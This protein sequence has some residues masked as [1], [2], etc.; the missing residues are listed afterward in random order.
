M[1]SI[2][3]A[4][5]KT[6]TCST[7]LKWK[8]ENTV[9]VINSIKSKETRPA[10]LEIR[11]EAENW[12]LSLKYG[13]ANDSRLT[14]NCGWGLSRKFKRFGFDAAIG[15]KLSATT[16]RDQGT[17]PRATIE[18]YIEPSPSSVVAQIQIINWIPYDDANS[19]KCSDRMGATFSLPTDF[20]FGAVVVTSWWCRSDVIGKDATA[21]RTNTESKQGHYLYKT[22]KLS[23]VAKRFYYSTISL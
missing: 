13:H 8:K 11:L 3:T 9:E 22:M 19:T 1:F 18:I 16:R 14:T 7:P 20:L 17:V 12:V 2:P 10:S 6:C 4:P 15:L 21:W 5:Y 23:N